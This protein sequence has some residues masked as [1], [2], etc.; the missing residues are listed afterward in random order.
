MEGLLQVK[1]SGKGA[2]SDLQ[3]THIVLRDTEKNRKSHVVLWPR[4]YLRAATQLFTDRLGY[5]TG[6]LL[7]RLHRQV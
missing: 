5:E 6:G 7:R 1:P 2:P 3:G 4:P